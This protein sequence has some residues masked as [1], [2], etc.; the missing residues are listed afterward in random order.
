MADRKFTRDEARQALVDI[1]YGTAT[2]SGPLGHDGADLELAKQLLADRW[3]RPVDHGPGRTFYALSRKGRHALHAWTPAPTEL[4]RYQRALIK[5][6]GDGHFADHGFQSLEEVTEAQEDGQISDGFF[7]A[8]MIELSDDVIDGRL[9]PLQPEEARNRADRVVRDM[10]RVAA[11]VDEAADHLEMALEDMRDGSA[12]RF[13]RD[14][15][16]E[17]REQQLYYQ[18]S[19]P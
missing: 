2:P 5:A 1:G 16:A 12:E 14:P 6:Y 7:A 10:A 13:G 9:E 4:N 3:L 8:L 15:E 18:D 19:K 11:A 17:R